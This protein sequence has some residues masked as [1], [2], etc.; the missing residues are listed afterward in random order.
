VSISPHKPQMR[1][2]LSVTTEQANPKQLG[3]TAAQGARGG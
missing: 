2:A 1:I 3:R